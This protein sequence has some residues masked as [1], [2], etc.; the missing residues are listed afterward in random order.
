MSK[1]IFTKR[2]DLICGKLDALADLIISGIDGNTAID[3]ID[4]VNDI[5]HDAQRMERKL[6]SRKQEALKLTMLVTDISNMC[7]GDLAMGYK[8]DAQSIG[9]DIYRVTGMTNPELNDAVQ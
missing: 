6:I 2:D 9:E 4:L 7:I 3:A 1:N 5:R 8:I